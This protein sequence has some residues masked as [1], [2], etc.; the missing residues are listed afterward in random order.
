MTSHWKLVPKL[1]L[2][3]GMIVALAFG[4]NEASACATCTQPDPIECLD[5]PNPNAFCDNICVVEQD[6]SGGGCVAHLN[7]CVCFE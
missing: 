3:A 2:V 5:Q 4:A 7:A 6:C 1:L